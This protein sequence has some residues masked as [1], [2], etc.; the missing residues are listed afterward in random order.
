MG[1]RH[2]QTFIRTE[3][4]GG[5]HRVNIKNEVRKQTG[6]PL[7]VVDLKSLCG[8]ISEKDLPGLLCGGRYE[9]VYRQLDSFFHE[10]TEL[11]VDLVFFNHGP[12]QQVKFAT[13]QERQIQKYDK[14][15][16]IINAV[17]TNVY[18]LNLLVASFRDKIP[19]NTRYSLEEAVKKHGTYKL[20]IERDCDQDLTA[21][22]TLHHA[23]A[24]ITNDTDFIIFDGP[25]RIW[26]SSTL[27]MEGLTIYEYNRTNLLQYLKLSAHQLPLL[28]TLSGNDIINYDEVRPFHRRLGHP[29][30]KF[31]TIANFIRMRPKATDLSASNNNSNTDE[32]L[33]M[34]LA[35]NNEF[36]HHLWAGQPFELTTYFIDLRSE[37]KGFEYAKLLFPVFE[38]QAGILLW[39]KQDV[40]E[41]TLIV[42][43]SH[44]TPYTKE[45]RCVER[46]KEITPPSIT[47]LLSDDPLVQADTRDTKLQL[48]C[49]IVS[50][51]LDFHRFQ[52]VPQKLWIAVATL[53]YL[54]EKKILELFEADLFLL[55][56]YRASTE[57]YDPKAVKYPDRLK[58]RP[59]RIAFLFT[60]TYKQFLAALERLGFQWEC[61]VAYLRFDGPLFHGLYE[62]CRESEGFFDDIKEW[63]LYESIVDAR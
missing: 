9:V 47:D 12:I 29:K 13:W 20:A 6:T 17:D 5:Y 61:S 57:S 25:W 59:F 4:H 21:Y 15:N 24:V 10:L 43:L 31:H 30:R 48:F 14:S 52:S 7:I 18:N 37:H 44:S 56:S 8:L 33:T 26:V 53:Y 28:A 63:R 55:V 23:M 46:P 35:Q 3:V 16:D 36:A 42:K 1:V 39:D 50:D 41:F 40:G 62:E 51:K 45:Q 54:I 19:S 11:G 32:I 34:L 22:A 58:G 49:W 27:D 60:E 2:L 38:R